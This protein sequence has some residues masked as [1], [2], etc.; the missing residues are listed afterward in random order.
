[1]LCYDWSEGAKHAIAEA[2]RAFPGRRALVL[3]VWETAGSADFDRS[4]ETVAQRIAREGAELARAAG[5]D[6]EPL[7]HG[8]GEAR[9]G[10]TTSQVWQTAVAVAADRDVAAIVV[11]ARGRSDMS[12]ALLGSVSLGAASHADR[13]VLVVPPARRR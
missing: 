2:A 9:P 8:T 7:V 6:A 3:H 1:M 13:P 10:R 11:G 5:L 4:A 12:G